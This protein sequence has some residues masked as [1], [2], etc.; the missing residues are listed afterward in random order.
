MAEKVAFL[1]G[2]GTNCVPCFAG[3]K[4]KKWE[5]FSYVLSAL[6]WLLLNAALNAAPV[7]QAGVISL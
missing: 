5:L 7:C 6:I 4:V 2:N 3:I 1:L